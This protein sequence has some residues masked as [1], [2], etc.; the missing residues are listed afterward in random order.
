[1]IFYVR[2]EQVFIKPCFIVLRRITVVGPK[3]S[4]QM[5]CASLGLVVFSIII[6]ATTSDF[7][8]SRST[9]HIYYFLSIVL[10]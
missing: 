8:I 6:F 2:P 7:C 9:S 1:M 3:S 4:S 10:D 5:Y